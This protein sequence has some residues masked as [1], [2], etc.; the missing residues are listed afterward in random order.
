M[1]K[2]I[3]FIFTIC[4]IYV[5]EAQKI[6]GKVVY[7]EESNIDKYY[8][9]TSLMIFNDTV[10]Y[11]KY[12][13]IK[14]AKLFVRKVYREDKIDETIL[15]KNKETKYVYTTKK[16]TYFT[17]TTWDKTMTVKEDAFNWNWKILEETKKIGTFNCQKASIEFR[18]RKYFAWFTLDVPVS[19]GP[20]KFKELPGLILEIHDSDNLWKMSAKTIDISIKEKCKIPFDTKELNNIFSIKEYLKELKRLVNEELKK[21]ASQ[22]PKGMKID[23]DSNCEGCDKPTLEIFKK[24]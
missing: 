1:K 20:W 6:C 8:K 9:T 19:F 13:K 11:T 10:S 24:E 23:L 15:S 14:E 7:E 22:L 16:D 4:L 21:F 5:V 2:I 12:L 17:D 3:A 18:G